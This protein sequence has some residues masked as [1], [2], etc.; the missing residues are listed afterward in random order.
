M[1]EA[2]LTVVAAEAAAEVEVVEEATEGTEEERHQLP[3][4]T[5]TTPT[6]R[7]STLTFLLEMCLVSVK[8]ISVGGNLHI[9]VLCQP[10]AHGKTSSHQSLQRNEILTSPAIQ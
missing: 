5:P 9:S 4:T 10:P 1:V 3:P 2:A 7:P 8:C 6:G